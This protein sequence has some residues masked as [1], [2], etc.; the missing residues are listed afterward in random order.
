LPE[1][2]EV[3]AAGH[4]IEV[5][6]NAEDPWNDYLPSAGRLL[7]VDWPQNELVRIDTGMG[8]SVGTQYDSLIAK[9]IA[10]GETRDEAI[11]TLKHALQETHMLG[12]Y[13]NQPLALKAL[14]EPWFRAGE[15]YIDTVDKWDIGK[16]PV[17]DSFA[18]AAAAVF[19]GPTPAPPGAWAELGAWRLT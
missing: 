17:P 16:R 12:L 1:Q 13:T 7:R 9:L 5:R 3:Y 4:A 8:S 15:T 10:W 14:D 18:P 6:L 2:E 11:T 19:A